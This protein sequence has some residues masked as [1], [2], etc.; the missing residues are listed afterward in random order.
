MVTPLI[1]IGTKSLEDEYSHSND[2]IKICE[3]HHLRALKSEVWHHQIWICHFF[4]HKKYNE[5]I[6]NE[7]QQLNI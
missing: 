2:D 1:W 7:N 5:F 6:N 4:K 3:P